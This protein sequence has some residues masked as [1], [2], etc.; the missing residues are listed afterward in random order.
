MLKTA[1]RL[2]QW[3]SIGAFPTCV[4][5]LARAPNHRRW[6]FYM[7]IDVKYRVRELAKDFGLSSK[8]IT[9]ILSKYGEGPQEH[10]AGADRPGAEHGV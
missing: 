9:E 4:F 1:Y 10:H 5:P 2:C 3:E 7:S 6:L 8:E